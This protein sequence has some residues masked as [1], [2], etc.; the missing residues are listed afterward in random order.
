ME[1]VEGSKGTIMSFRLYREGDGKWARGV[2]AVTLFMVGL[3]ASVNTF[4][5]FEGNDWGTDEL[6]VIPL[7]NWP[8]Q[9]Q[10]IL[11]V[12]IFIPFVLAGIWYYNQKRVSDFLIDT[13]KELIE[14][15]TWP[16]RV[17]TTKNSIIVVITCLVI[18]GWITLANL[19]FE[20]ATGIVYG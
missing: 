9:L 3:V 12:L 20:W 17:E 19:F 4:E 18:M 14:K 7:L 15:V 6:F 13:E 16:N 11:S 8:V 10:A 1:E 2:L 5:W